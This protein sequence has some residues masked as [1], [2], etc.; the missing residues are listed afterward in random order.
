[1]E[2]FAE[3][4]KLKSR[5][6][7][8]KVYWAVI[9]FVALT[10]GG[11]VMAQTNSEPSPDAGLVPLTP[12]ATYVPP[13]NTVTSGSATNAM[14]SSG[15]TNVANLG[16]VTVVGQLNQARSQ[17][18]PNLGATAYTHTADQIQAQAQ[19]ENAPMNQ[20]ILRSPGV[21]QDSAENGDLHV[22]GEHANLQYRINGV[23][24]PEGIT[25]GFGLELDPR[26]IESMQ[27][28]TGSL[29]AQYG[30]RTAGV[31]DITTKT[32]AFE[33]GGE[34]GVY[35][36]SF[37][38]F[39]PSFEYGDTVG[40]WDYFLNGSFDENDLGVENPTSS[41]NALHDHTDQYKSFLYASRLLSDTSRVTFMG[42]ASYT[43]YQIPDTSDLPVGTGDGVDWYKSMT[44]PP[45]TNSADLN[46]N[47]IEQNY[48]AVAAFQES[49]GDLNYQLAGYGRMSGVHFLPDPNGD[50]VFD[51]EASDVDRNLYS[52]G[53]QLDASYDLGDKHT[54]RA[55][56]MLLEEYLTDG[57]TTTVFPTTGGGAPDGAPFAIVQDS[58][59]HALY[60]GA[61]IQDEWKIIPHVTINY[62][63][64]FDEYDSTFDEEFQPSPR[65]NLIYEPT[66]WTTMHIGYSRYFTPPPLENVPAGNL[67]AFAGTSGAPAETQD[68]TVK[69]ESANYYDAGISQKIT[70]HLQ[71]GVDAY[72]KTAKNQ[73]DDGLF[74]QTLI[75]SAFNYAKGRVYGIEGTGSYNL[76]GFSAY[77]NLAWSQAYGKDWTSAQFL[78]SPADIAYVKNH[79]IYLDH[80]QLLSGN[81]GVSYTLKESERYSSLFYAD[82]IY[83]SGLRQ[84]G[85][86]V[87]DGAGDPV[88]NG[89]SVP[90]Y[91]SINLGVEEDFKIPHGRM[92]KARIDV[93]NVTDNIY[94][95][96][97]GSGI[98]VNAAQ[99][100]ERRGFFGTLTLEF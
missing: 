34:A 51:G 9:S 55:G 88:P 80:D 89:A 83:G 93:V 21:A 81:F 43:T 16:N 87:I 38:T 85:G 41:L 77:A 67:A 42:S 53:L 32:G 82:A 95:L 3:Q 76:G 1:M 100:G 44:T 49:A 14:A 15:S 68:D 29:P 7:R 71:L 86:G 63:A 54:I 69:A 4:K 33:N 20:I 94:E 45:N 79:W 78:F 37:N 58:T 2:K 59:A 66:D 61:Y 65:V 64:R 52:G 57:S 91:Y 50:L 6:R 12:V 30:F 99:Y 18:L 10:C 11:T 35:G 73:I 23:L 5:R 75:L 39:R 48:Y 98:G 31:I 28:I 36:G 8:R 47:Q 46:E 84:D 90:Q 60:A 96:R 19:G 56:G 74:G 72:Y 22:R 13:T 97:S 40:A 26:F 17:I 70:K 27:L 92:L 25:G 62:G 24:L